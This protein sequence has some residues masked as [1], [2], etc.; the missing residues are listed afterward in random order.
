[1]NTKENMKEVFWIALASVV[2][3]VLS[4]IWVIIKYYKQGLGEITKQDLFTYVFACQTRFPLYWIGYLLAIGAIIFFY[5]SYISEMPYKRALTIKICGILQIVFW[6]LILLSTFINLR[7]WDFLLEIIALISAI[8]A[9]VAWLISTILFL[10]DGQYRKTYLLLMGM[11]LFHL[12]GVLAVTFVV[13]LYVGKFIM[14]I[15]L[16]QRQIRFYEKKDEYGNVLERWTSE[17]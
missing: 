7:N 11:V 2:V 17:E 5:I 10:V 14:E 8:P 4:T 16:P 15:I 3:Y 9:I 12:I 6:V 1:M 13:M